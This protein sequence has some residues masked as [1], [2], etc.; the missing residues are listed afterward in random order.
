MNSIAATRIR[1]G[2]SQELFAM[3]LGVSRSTLSKAENRIRSLPTEAMLKLAQLEIHFAATVN[4]KLATAVLSDPP[5]INISPQKLNYLSK[6][7]CGRYREIERLEIKLQDLRSQQIKMEYASFLLEIAEKKSDVQ[8]SGLDPRFLPLQRY[9]IF[10][11]LQK[12]GPEAQEILRNKILIIKAAAALE[13]GYAASMKDEI[14]QEQPPQ[15]D[16]PIVNPLDPVPG[17]KN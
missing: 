6:A 2:L 17:S 16:A 7:M 11:K 13:A 1:L 12:C 14:E 15:P 3:E 5:P 9:G 8:E 10:K 4:D